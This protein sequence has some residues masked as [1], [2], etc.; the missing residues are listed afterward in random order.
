MWL[1]WNLQIYNSFYFK[2]KSYY[3]FPSLI[4]KYINPD[5]MQFL[6]I[7]ILILS[8]YRFLFLEGRD[9]GHSTIHIV[10]ETKK[11]TVSCS[12]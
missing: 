11:N 7:L 2:N 1:F 5:E 6:C 12:G 10:E 8:A 3:R 4:Y 9:T